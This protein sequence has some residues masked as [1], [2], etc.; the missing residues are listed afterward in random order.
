MT[1]LELAASLVP[2]FWLLVLADLIAHVEQA[3]RLKSRPVAARSGARTS[4]ATS[5][6]IAEPCGAVSA[7]RQASDAIPDGAPDGSARTRT[8]ISDR[9]Q[10]GGRESGFTGH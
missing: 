6:E 5:D 8:P 1:A 9:G 10:P 7:P 3:A 2:G 4:E